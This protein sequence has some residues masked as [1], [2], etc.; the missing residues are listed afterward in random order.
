[1]KIENCLRPGSREMERCRWEGQNFPP[2]KE[3]QQLEEEE[4]RILSQL[5]KK[6]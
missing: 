2:L 3:V 5:I 1:M 6:F 4:E